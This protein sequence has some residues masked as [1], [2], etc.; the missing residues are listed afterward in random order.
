VLLEPHAGQVVRQANL[1]QG[2]ATER[3]L[4]H[5]LSTLQLRTGLIA[6]VVRGE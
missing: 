4:L 3:F 2:D 1:I 5:F 6:G